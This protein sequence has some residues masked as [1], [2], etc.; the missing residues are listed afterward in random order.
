M[1]LDFCPCVYLVVHK[2]KEILQ[3]SAQR[4]LTFCCLV[5]MYYLYPL[6]STT[7]A[8]VRGRALLEKGVIVDICLDS[9][10]NRFRHLYFIF[11]RMPNG[12]GR[13]AEKELAK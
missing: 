7:T 12:G 3:K 10:R 2:G 11:I 13:E 8:V 4:V 6:K 9:R 1:F 5:K